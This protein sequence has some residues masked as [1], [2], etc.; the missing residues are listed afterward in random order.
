M[1]EWTYHIR[2]VTY[3]IHTPVRACYQTPNMYLVFGCLSDI[4]VCVYKYVHIHKNVC[5]CALLSTIC[6][7][8]QSDILHM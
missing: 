8:S 1:Q 3:T 6:T 2:R 4:Y 5:L 7:D